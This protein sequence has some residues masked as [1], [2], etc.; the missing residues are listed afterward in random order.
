[1]QEAID[2]AEQR[3]LAVKQADEERITT[4]FQKE[5]QELREQLNVTTQ[6]KETESKSSD[7]IGTKIHPHDAQRRATN[8]RAAKKQTV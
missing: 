1:M 4:D 5:I 6:V 2:A 8:M 7:D 3:W